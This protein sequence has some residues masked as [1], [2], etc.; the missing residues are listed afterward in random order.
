[1]L[2]SSLEAADGK[3]MP[4]FFEASENCLQSEKKSML[5]P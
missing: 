1:M 5:S 2:L 3:E 4:S